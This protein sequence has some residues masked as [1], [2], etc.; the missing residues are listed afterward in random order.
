MTSLSARANVVAPARVVRSSRHTARAARVAVRVVAEDEVE[1]PFVAP[2]NV[3]DFI[4]KGYIIMD[5]RSPDEQ[6]TGTKHVWNLNPLAAMT[7]EGPVVN[8]Y[9]LANVKRDFP[10]TMS[11]FLI[12]CDDG[13]DRSE[14]AYES[15]AGKGYTAVKVIEGGIDAYLEVDPLTEKDLVKQKMVDTNMGQD[16]SDLVTGVDTRLGNQRIY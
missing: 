6:K 3:K 11:R 12:A 4:D 15:I 2:A 5:I 7:E 13:T 1:I 16:L 10:N 14:M 9:F 8:P